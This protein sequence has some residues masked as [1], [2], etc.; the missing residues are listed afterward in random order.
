MNTFSLIFKNIN[1]ED[2]YRKYL[3]FLSFFLSDRKIEH[4]ID[5]NGYFLK[6]SS[7]IEI[8]KKEIFGRVIIYWTGDKKVLYEILYD[9]CSKFIENGDISSNNN[10]TACC[11]LA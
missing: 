7:N 11:T 1:N 10:S 8:K 3:E 9:F 5:I 6:I 4:K 2:I